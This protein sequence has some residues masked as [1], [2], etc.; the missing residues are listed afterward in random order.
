MKHKQEVGGQEGESNRQ[1][2]QAFGGESSGRAP[3]EA[4]V[5][6]GLQH[7]PGD[8][9]GRV[10][11]QESGK[12]SAKDHLHPQTPTLLPLLGVTGVFAG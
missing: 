8:T 3:H 12:H 7:V 6:H 11:G 4:G 9:E 5:P 1:G 10:W 2:L